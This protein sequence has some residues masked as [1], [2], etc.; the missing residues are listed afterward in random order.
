M[1][2]TVKINESF[3]LNFSS[4][5]ADSG[6]TVADVDVRFEN[7]KDDNVI[8]ARLNTWLKAI[9]RENIVVELKGGK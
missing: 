1:A 8:V 9:N 6:D 2:K 3:S 4:R 7:P 5:E